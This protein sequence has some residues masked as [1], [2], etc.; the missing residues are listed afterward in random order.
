VPARGRGR[1]TP[2]AGA[3]NIHDQRPAR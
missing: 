3:D 2:T 1:R